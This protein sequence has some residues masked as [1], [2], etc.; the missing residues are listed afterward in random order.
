MQGF[1]SK[2][3]PQGWRFLPKT[4]G[5]TLLSCPIPEL[6]LRPERKWLTD[7]AHWKAQ[8]GGKRKQRQIV[9]KTSGEN[10]EKRNHQKGKRHN[11]SVKRANH[12]KGSMNV[13]DPMELV[14]PGGNNHSS[15]FARCVCPSA[16]F[17][18]QAG[19]TLHPLSASGKR[20][21]AKRKSSEN[22]KSTSWHRRKK[23]ALLHLSKHRLGVRQ[24][25]FLRLCGS[26]HTFVQ[27]SFWA[28]VFRR[29]IPLLR[30][31]SYE[32]GD[33]KREFISKS[34]N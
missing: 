24:C 22:P 18:G 14:P 9:E 27:N 33:K 13:S 34:R 25:P 30:K 2:Y 29:I 12:N 21:S 7:A 5:L 31:K 28:M 26:R 3:Y 19:H 10:P 1:R 6:P 23:G 15:R 16:S 17:M 4:G 20:D 8:N 32:W 11:R